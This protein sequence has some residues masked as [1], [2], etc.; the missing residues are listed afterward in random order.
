M[1]ALGLLVGGIVHLAESA[2]R[3][4]TQTL[5]RHSAAKLKRALYQRPDH[6]FSGVLNQRVRYT[7]GELESRTAHYGRTSVITQALNRFNGQR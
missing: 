4:I 5:A 2:K 6:L 7:W 1:A 3:S